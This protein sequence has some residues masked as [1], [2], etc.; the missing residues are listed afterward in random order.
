MTLRDNLKTDVPLIFLNSTEFSEKITY[1]LKSGGRRGIQAI[2]DRNPP[3][4]YDAAGEVVL[5]EFTIVVYNNCKTGVEADEVNTGGDEVE[6][7]VKDGDLQ[8]TRKT[9]MHMSAH[10]LGVVELALM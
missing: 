8:T 2:I 7:I 9:V 10:D 3:A 4:I 5:P 1:F 6:L